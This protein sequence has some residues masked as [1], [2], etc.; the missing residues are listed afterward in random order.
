MPPKIKGASKAK[1]TTESKEEQASPPPPS[2]PPR[3][4]NERSWQRYWATNPHQKSF[5]ELGPHG[6]S[7]A[8]LQAYNNAE[9]VKPGVAAD[10]LSKKAQKE[11]WKQ[12]NEASLPLRRL[13]RP[14]QF[15]WGH[16]AE[17]RDRG[18]YTSIEDFDARRAREDRLFLLQIRSDRFRNRGARERIGFVR[19]DTSESV[20]YGCSEEDIEAERVR[21]KEIADL[22]MELYGVRS[23]SYAL[24]PE[25]D[26]VAPIPQA[27]PEG[28]LAAIAY[29]DDYAESMS[30]LRAVMAEKEHSPRCLRLTEHVISMNPAHYTVWLYR[31]AIVEALNIS[32]PDEIEWLN[33]VSLEHLKN[34][35]IWHHRQLLLDHYYPAIASSAD[36][37]R[38]LARSELDFVSQMLTLDAKNYHVWSYRQ[39]LVRKLGAALWPSN[40]PGYAGDEEGGGAELSDLGRLIDEDVRNNSAWS[41]RFF[42]VFSDPGRSTPGSHATERDPAVPAAVVDRELAYARRKIDVAPQNQSPWNYLRGVLAKGGRDL[43]EV[44]TF[45]EGYVEALGEEG[46]VVRSS[47]ALDYLADAYKEAGDRERAD[48]CLRRLAEKW[49]RVRRGYW[50]YRR[51]MLDN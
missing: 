24:D 1:A 49:D 40:D 25:W 51:R 37:V 20:D 29:P 42:I 35:Q 41:H 44:R 3:T 23:G 4:P 43:G 14:R 30:Y 15:Q 12:A 16:D 26:D 22:R 46:E 50:E 47:H 13:P 36:D 28:A 11:L 31:F 38:D 18:E 48:L 21:R 33:A 32:I 19:Y 17:G 8:A 9:Y 5:E 34:Y 45:A 10:V 7:P 6:M 39:Y 27:E 2:P